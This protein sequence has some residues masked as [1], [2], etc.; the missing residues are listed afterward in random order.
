MIVVI[1][2]YPRL[3]ATIFNYMAA[4]SLLSS[5]LSISVLYMREM[6]DLGKHVVPLHNQVQEEEIPSSCLYIHVYMY[7]SCL[8][9]ANCQLQ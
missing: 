5:L 9:D 4:R 6:V 1:E 3:T 8:Y 2:R 7:M